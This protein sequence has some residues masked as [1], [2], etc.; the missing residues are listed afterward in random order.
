MQ[1]SCGRWCFQWQYE[2][3]LILIIW[4]FHT[5]E[6]AY[7]LKFICIPEINTREAFQ[8]IWEHR[9]NGEKWRC[10]RFTL[11]AEVKEGHALPSW[12]SSY[13]EDQCSFPSTGGAGLFAFLHLPLVILMFLTAPKYSAEVLASVPKCKK[14]VMCVTEK[15]VSQIIFVQAW[16]TGLLAMSSTSVNQLYVTRYVFT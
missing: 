4:R 3:H 12:L 5:W 9:A 14:A 11:P 8:G 15:P 13:T 1:N 7:S 6:L 16:V 2:L 10:A